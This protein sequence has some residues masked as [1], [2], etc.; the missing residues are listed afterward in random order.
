MGKK[1]TQTFGGLVNMDSKLTLMAGDLKQHGLSVG[2][3]NQEI[4]EVLA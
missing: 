3:G 2:Y 4:N 1:N